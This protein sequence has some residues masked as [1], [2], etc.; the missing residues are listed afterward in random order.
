MSVEETRTQ[1]VDDY[2]RKAKEFYGDKNNSRIVSNDICCDASFVDEDRIKST[3]EKFAANAGIS[4]EDLLDAALDIHP[5]LSLTITSKEI[6]FERIR[7]DLPEDVVSEIKAHLSEHYRSGN[8]KMPG[9]GIW[10]GNFLSVAPS[11]EGL[12]KVSVEGISTRGKPLGGTSSANSAKKKSIS[13]KIPSKVARALEAAANARNES[14]VERSTLIRALIQ[15]WIE[16]G[17]P[18]LRNYDRSLPELN[19]N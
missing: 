3:F 5:T 19:T 11:Q 16:A 14:G 7:F 6:A 17:C 9:I 13:A 18:S 8:T 10:L 15:A 4:I 2:I 12:R 1:E